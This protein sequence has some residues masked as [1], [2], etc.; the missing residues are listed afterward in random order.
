V[1]SYVPYLEPL[2][3]VP[4]N[5]DDYSV[6][7]KSRSVRNVNKTNA[8]RVIGWCCDHAEIEYP[9]W[10]ESVPLDDLKVLENLAMY[11]CV[12]LPSIETFLLARESHMRTLRERW[13]LDTG[14]SGRVFVDQAR[15]Q[16]IVYALSSS[17]RGL[18]ELFAN[19]TY[20]P[21]LAASL[22]ILTGVVASETKMYLLD[23]DVFDWGPS[24]YSDFL[25]GKNPNFVYPSVST[26]YST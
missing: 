16:G 1:P 4:S 12:E 25:D 11:F 19:A 21:Q 9:G 17:Y 6:Y 24:D 13:V 23:S 2:P 3:P 26:K 14:V 22:R 5:Q 18:E 7:L 20:L 10:L 15:V 8:Y